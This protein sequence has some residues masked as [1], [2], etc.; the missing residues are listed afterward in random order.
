MREILNNDFEQHAMMILSARLSRCKLVRY[1]LC[2]VYA[3]FI[4]L[5]LWAGYVSLRDELFCS[6]RF[7]NRYSNSN[8]YSC[9]ESDFLVIDRAYNCLS[10]T[11]AWS[12]SISEALKDLTLYK[13]NMACNRLRMLAIVS[14]NLPSLHRLRLRFC[15]D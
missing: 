15:S 7:V 14:R 8:S 11:S 6:H 3:I 5:F 12:K 1:I 2:R 13:Y 9:C 10:F 4:Y